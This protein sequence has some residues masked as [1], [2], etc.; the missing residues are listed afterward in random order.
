MHELG[1]NAGNQMIREF[2]LT[3][4]PNINAKYYLVDGGV[5]ATTGCRFGGMEMHIAFQDK[6]MVRNSVSKFCSEIVGPWWA[7]IRSDRKSVINSAIKS[8]F[9][10]QFNFKGCS[11]VDNIEREYVA[12]KRG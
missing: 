11:I 5:I 12:L 4:F 3:E 6:S 2:G 9:E 10:F 1:R 8:G 7:L